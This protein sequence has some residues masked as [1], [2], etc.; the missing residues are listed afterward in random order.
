MKPSG[1]ASLLFVLLSFLL[2]S[3]EVDS[4]TSLLFNSP[5]CEL[6]SQS[7][8]VFPETG[9]PY[10]TIKVK[11]NGDG[12]TAYSVSFYIKLKNGDYIVDDGDTEVG[13]LEYK[14][15]RTGKIKF[16]H[17]KE[18]EVFSSREITLYWYDA[19]GGYYYQLYN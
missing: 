1:L 6:I 16:P 5:E 19:E 13:T 4:P 11:N 3:C 12:P 17:L 8:I 15:S 14:E 10:M 2:I 18:T 9:F 7:A